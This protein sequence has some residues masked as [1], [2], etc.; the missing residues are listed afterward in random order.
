[1]SPKDLPPSPVTPTRILSGHAAPTGALQMYPMGY[2]AAPGSRATYGLMTPPTT[3]ERAR[4]HRGSAGYAVHPVFNPRTLYLNVAMPLS[5]IDPRALRNAHESFTIPPA[6]AV[7]INVLG[8]FRFEVRARQTGG[9]TVRDVFEGILQAM[10]QSAS[11]EEAR[12]FA[13]EVQQSVASTRTPRR[14][15]Y[16]GPRLLF[17]AIEVT[18]VSGG[19][20][21]CDLH[22]ANVPQ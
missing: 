4:G 3:P 2:P 22:L 13:P 16:L 6:N 19:I 1:M 14:Y 17:N 10:A 11:P 7:H 18:H 21:Y 9:V 5:N 15:K 8:V 20:V 12:C